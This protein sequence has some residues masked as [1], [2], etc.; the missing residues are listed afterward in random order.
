MKANTNAKTETKN[1]KSSIQQKTNIKQ[2]KNHSK[3]TNTST[4]DK[5]INKIANKKIK[6]P[7]KY[8]VPNYISLIATTIAYGYQYIIRVSPSVTM[9]E[10]MEKYEISSSSF[11]QFS[12][13]FH[14]GYALANIPF[15]LMLDKMGLRITFMIS[16]LMAFIG[17]C[18]ILWSESWN[19]LIFGRFISGAGSA[20]CN[21]CMIK[22]IAHYFSNNF[23]KTLGITTSFG[24]ACAIFGGKPLILIINKM[25]FETVMYGIVI[26]GALLSL[27][28]L[29]IES[30]KS[31]STHSDEPHS[32]KS[33]L[34]SVFTNYRLYSVCLFGGLM[35]GT[36]EGF[37]DVWSVNLLINR[38][39]N[40]QNANLV[41]SMI[42]LGTA[43]GSSL[44]G[45]ITDKT[46]EHYAISFFSGI[47][48]F[49]FLV[50]VIFF[51]QNY[52][53]L[54]GIMVIIGITCGYQVPIAEKIILLSKKGTLGVTT[55]FANTILMSFGYIFH[56]LIG[57]I[58]DST[59]SIVYGVSVVPIFC[60]I[61]TI[62]FMYLYLK[63]RS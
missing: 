46:K 6:K 40:M 58:Y 54:L 24:L 52:Y 25:D 28:S 49:A 26:L 22:V 23:S 31:N 15:G 34:I 9:N 4:N 50:M 8:I 27:L 55:S 16:I 3:E 59:Q 13:I 33:S 62:G 45:Y 43:I 10:I 2:G 14:I 29:V 35:V 51:N 20:G 44:L 30:I 42:F 36:L 60:I 37:A 12:G 57:H 11:A 18:P 17:F 56:T 47:I 39:M 5:S 7:K 21:L 48:M 61:G 63:N 32:I 19:M 53:V 41:A 38:G 1:A